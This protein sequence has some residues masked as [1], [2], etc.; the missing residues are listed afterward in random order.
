MDELNLGE[1]LDPC[2]DAGR[3]SDASLCALGVRFPGSSAAAGVDPPV[4]VPVLDQQ[5]LAVPDEPDSG[6][7][8]HADG[9]EGIHERVVLP[10]PAFDAPLNEVDLAVLGGE[11][12]D[13]RVDVAA[14]FCR[15]G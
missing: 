9:V 6:T 15:H 5:D 11:I 12:R 10:D 1:P 2:L 13:E 4:Y 7:T 8:D 14:Q 3:F